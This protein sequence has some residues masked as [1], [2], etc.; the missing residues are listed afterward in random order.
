V[1]AIQT[2]LC[3]CP[4]VDAALSCIEFLAEIKIGLCKR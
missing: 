3:M 1:Y 4:I 2:E